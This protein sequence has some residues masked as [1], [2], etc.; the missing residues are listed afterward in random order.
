MSKRPLSDPKELYDLG[1]D[2]DHPVTPDM[3]VSGLRFKQAV[4]V[5]T[6]ISITIMGELL[7]AVLSGETPASL[8]SADSSS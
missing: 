4:C 1:W 7:D 5:S 8:R 3:I 2:F 6:E